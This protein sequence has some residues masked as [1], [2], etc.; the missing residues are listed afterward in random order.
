MTFV[1]RRIQV[2][3]RLGQGVTFEE[4][5]TD[6]IYIDGARVQAHIDKVV[7]PG[8]GQAQIRIYG[9]T[10]SLMNQLSSLNAADMNTR[11]NQV[12]VL[13]GDDIS[14]M[15]VAFQ[16]QMILGQQTLNTAPETSLLVVGQAGYLA[17]VQ[18]MPPTSYGGTA[19]IGVIMS[20]IAAAAGWQFE[21][22]G[23][24]LQLA[25]PYLWGSPY[26]QIRSCHR[27]LGGKF[28]Y[29]VDDGKP[30]TLA[31]WPEGGTNGTLVPL[32]STETGLVGYPDYSTSLNGLDVKTIFNPQLKVGGAVKIQVATDCPMIVA[33]GVW[34][35]YDI[36]HDLESETP[37]GQWFTRFRAS[38]N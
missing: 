14:G 1:R 10:P 36:Q 8:T 25:T 31:I 13:A 15:A 5:G 17:A 7:G 18:L 35:V 9:L 21:N 2:V 19:D 28:E 24:S 29:T 23:V 27:A 11:M 16:G 22:H 4:S 38:S 3:F 26:D 20:N 32:I 37:G 30:Q 34:K 33:N 6:T 12:T